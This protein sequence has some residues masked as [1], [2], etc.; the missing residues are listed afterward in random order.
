MSSRERERPHWGRILITTVIGFVILRITF[1]LTPD[2][3]HRGLWQAIGVEA[4]VLTLVLAAAFFVERSL[5]VKVAQAVAPLASQVQN[6]AAEVRS[7][8]DLVDQRRREQR[9]EHAAAVAD[10]DIPTFGSMTSAL[11]R[12]ADLDLLHDGTLVVQAAAAGLGQRISFGYSVFYTAGGP[13]SGTPGLMV[14]L[15]GAEVEWEDSMDVGQVARRLDDELRRQRVPASDRAIDW[16]YVFSEVRRTLAVAFEPAGSGWN[17][18]GELH[19]L[20]GQWAVTSAGLEHHQRG[21]V[22][23]VAEFPP[24]R[25]TYSGAGAASEHPNPVWK[26]W[27]CPKPDWADQAEW[28]YV[29]ALAKSTLPPVPDVLG[30]RRRVTPTVPGQR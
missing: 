5:M 16:E 28:D 17:L 23:A 25:L 20:A 12:A 19:E 10:L 26:D 8:R 15:A 22:I 13:V 1:W 11:V 14:S 24:R 6:L 18:A 4:G 21:M 27:T 3:D 2:E 9:R 29:F 7:L 30:L